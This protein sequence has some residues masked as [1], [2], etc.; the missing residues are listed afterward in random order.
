MD[1][2]TKMTTEPTP[3][4]CIVQQELLSTMENVCM[5][6]D[7]DD[8]KFEAMLHTMQQSTPPEQFDLQIA[9]LSTIL[10]TFAMQHYENIT[11]T[12]YL[13]LLCEKGEN[14]VE[15]Y[16]TNLTPLLMRLDKVLDRTKTIVGSQ[17]K[18]CTFLSDHCT[19]HLH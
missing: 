8:V 2:I 9:A 13:R 15:L 3:N 14:P 12:L 19:E 7:L 4:A 11:A 17:T 10:K 6:G 18:F 1:L 16:R 5:I